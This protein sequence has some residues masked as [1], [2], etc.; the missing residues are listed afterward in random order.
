MSSGTQSHQS[1]S[2]ML[3]YLPKLV[4]IFLCLVALVWLSLQDLALYEVP[5]LFMS[6]SSSHDSP[7]RKLDGKAGV[8]FAPHSQFHTRLSLTSL[9][10]A[11]VE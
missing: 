10:I 5:K 11:S 8:L 2:L 9:E 3:N 7:K 1:I 6:C 4:I